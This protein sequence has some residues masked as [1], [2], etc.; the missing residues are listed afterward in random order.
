M[1]DGYK[2]VWR[3]QCHGRWIR[4]FTEQQAAE[5]VATKRKSFGTMF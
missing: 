3:M 1:D 5:Q 4:H 2:S